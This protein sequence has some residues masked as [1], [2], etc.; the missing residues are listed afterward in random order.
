MS[1]LCPQEVDGGWRFTVKT[2]TVTDSNTGWFSA[3]C[4]HVSNDCCAKHCSFFSDLC[5][6]NSQWFSATHCHVSSHFC[7]TKC[8]CFL[9]DHCCFLIGFCATKLQWFLV[10]HHRVSS[11]FWTTKHRGYLAN[12]CHYFS[13][14]SWLLCHQ[15]SVILSNPS[16]RFQILL[17]NQT[18]VFFRDPLQ[19]SA[20]CVPSNVGVF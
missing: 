11:H 13:G 19:S 12:C 4:G 20:A 7:A 16:L 15:F 18:L 2:V 17:C 6:T 5:A 8:W 14:N 1:W 3:T 10:T 9:A